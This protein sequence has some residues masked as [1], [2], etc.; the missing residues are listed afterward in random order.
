MTDAD[1]LATAPA[2]DLENA[3]V[4]LVGSADSDKE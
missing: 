1:E 3:D 2:D 4:A